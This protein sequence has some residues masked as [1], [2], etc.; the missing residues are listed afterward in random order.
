M[1][2]WRKIAKAETINPLD[3]SLRPT[4]EVVPPKPFIPP[5]NPVPANPDAGAQFQKSVAPVVP[6]PPLSVKLAKV[7]SGVTM[8]ITNRPLLQDL[9]KEAQAGAMHRAR[10]AKEAALHMRRYSDDSDRDEQESCESCKESSAVPTQMAEKLAAAVEF[11]LKLGGDAGALEILEATECGVSP[12]PGTLGQ[13]IAKNQPEP[14][15]LMKTTP[16][17]AVTALKDTIDDPPGGGERQHTALTAGLGKQSSAIPPDVY[18]GGIGLPSGSDLVASNLAAINYTK[19]QAKANAKRDMA[20]YINEPAQS[21][22]HDTTLNRVLDNTASAK[23]AHKV[24]QAKLARANK[25][26]LVRMMRGG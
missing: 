6:Q 3:Q 26:A 12:Q 5:I 22:A 17:G 14:S 25:Q 9:V 23:I 7:R 10:I 18:G 13:A 2:Y 16:K 8:N 1:G 4:N 21:A 24:M 15:T 20:A 11:I 19:R